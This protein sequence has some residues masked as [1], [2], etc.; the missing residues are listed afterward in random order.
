MEYNLENFPCYFARSAEFDEWK[1]G[2][3]K[4]LR[5]LDNF[6][7]ST[8]AWKKLEVSEGIRYMIKEILGE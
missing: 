1:E 6:I 3:K 5:E 2:F 8:P 7:V 4:E